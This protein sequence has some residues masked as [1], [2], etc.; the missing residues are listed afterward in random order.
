M[1]IEIDQDG[2]Y[3]Y[4]GR[5]DIAA[6]VHRALRER[7][8]GTATNNSGNNGSTATT[9]DI[10][11][12][13]L[14]MEASRFLYELLTHPGTVATHS[15]KASTWASMK[16]LSNLI[17]S[18]SDVCPSAVHALV[19]PCC[20]VFTC[21]CAPCF[22]RAQS[23][24]TTYHFRSPLSPLSPCAGPIGVGSSRLYPDVKAH[25]RNHVEGN[26]ST[27]DH[28]RR[29]EIFHPAIENNRRQKVKDKKKRIKRQTKQ[30]NDPARTTSTTRRRLHIEPSPVS[31]QIPHTE[32]PRRHGSG[33]W[34]PVPIEPNPTF[35]DLDRGSGRVVDE[36]DE[37]QKKKEKT[38]A[39]F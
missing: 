29:I 19:R 34:F 28:V 20:T 24:L 10:E 14:H 27:L 7:G 6:I 33:V 5:E 8:V 26:V 2:S 11:D 31:F 4:C 39:V 18:L 35:V 23:S 36:N 32:L 30:G 22:F 17:D 12:T 13:Y 9:T 21:A 15:S 16:L 25:G 3:G 37:M 1:A 38:I